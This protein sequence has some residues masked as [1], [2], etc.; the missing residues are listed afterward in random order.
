MRHSPANKRAIAVPAF[1]DADKSALR[2]PVRKVTSGFGELLV[3]TSGDM[4]FVPGHLLRLVFRSV[5]P[6]AR[7]TR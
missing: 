4:T 2:V 6:A 1:E 3:K 5:E 7:R